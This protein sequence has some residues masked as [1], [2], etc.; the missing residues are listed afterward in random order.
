MAGIVATSF[1]DQGLL[2]QFRSNLP[3]KK[4]YRVSRG[5]DLQVRPNGFS[6]CALDSR[7]ILF[8]RHLN[9]STG[10]LLR[11]PRPLLRCS[12][13]L[14]QS[15]QRALHFTQPL[16]R[17]TRPL[18]RS[19]QPL[20]RSSR[21]TLRCSGPLLRSNRHAIHFT[22][23]LLANA[24]PLLLNSPRLLR[25]NWRLLY[26]TLGLK[27]FTMRGYLTADYAEKRG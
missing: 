6:I 3:L 22:Q 25:C 15:S 1:G 16:L 23:P 4:G 17:C 27:R 5:A 8:S 21:Q 20:L 19:R 24:R 9:R 10:P 7:P 18:L 14:L 13:P 12:P 11:I 2:R 26:S